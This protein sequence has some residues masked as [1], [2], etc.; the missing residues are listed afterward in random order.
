[1]HLAVLPRRGGALIAFTVVQLL[2]LAALQFKA[3]KGLWV[4][5][6]RLLVRVVRAPFKLQL[7][8][9]TRG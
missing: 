6:M 7:Q 3:R 9:T 1:M 4:P 5:P 8:R 2:D